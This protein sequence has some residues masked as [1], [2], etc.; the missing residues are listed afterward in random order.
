MCLL[1]KGRFEWTDTTLRA[2]EQLKAAMLSAPILALPDF[3]KTFVVK[4]DA[5]DVGIDTVLSQGGHP[6]TFM[7]KALTHHTRPLSTYDKELFAIVLAMEKWC[8]YLLG[9][10]FT[11]GTN[12]SSLRH[13]LSQRVSVPTQ[14]WLAKLLGYDFV[15]EYKKG[16]EN[17]AADSLFRLTE[18]LCTLSMIT[19]NL[20]ECLAREQDSDESTC[21]LKVLTRQHP[22]SIPGFMMYGNLLCHKGQTVVPREATLARELIKHFHSSTIVGHEGATKTIGM[23]KV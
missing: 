1:R 19:T 23:V 15:I 16:T 10:H 18:H 4:T 13:I 12:H 21:L 8:P 20:W 9:Q 3:G 11:V 6:I 2:F 14:R 7:S 22:G 17:L 5:S